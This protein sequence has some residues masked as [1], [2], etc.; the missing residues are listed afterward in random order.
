MKYFSEN[1]FKGDRGKRLA[2]KMSI[3]RILRELFGG[4]EA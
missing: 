3:S 2:Y 4:G 1:V